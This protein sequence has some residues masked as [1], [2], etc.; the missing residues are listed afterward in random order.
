[1][2]KNNSVLEE[3]KRKIANLAKEAKKGREAQRRLKK[4]EKEYAV[5]WEHKFEMTKAFED[6]Q[7]AVNLPA[8]Y[9]DKDLNINGSSKDFPSLTKRVYELV[10]EKMNIREFL[11]EGDFDKISQYLDKVKA[12]ESLPYN[13]GGEWELRYQGLNDSDKIGGNWIACYKGENWEIK[14]ERGT[15]KIKHKPHLDD[16]VDCYL[17]TADEYGGADQDIK[18][19]YRIKTSRKKENIRDLSLVISGSQS[20]EERLCDIFGYTVCTGSYNNSR[21]RIQRK[22]LDMVMHLETLQPN[23]RYEITVERIGGMIRRKL[24][25][26]K[27]GREA[28]PLEAIDSSASYDGENHLGFTT[29]SGEAEIFDIEIYTR[30]SGFSIDQFRIPFEIEAGINDERLKDRTYKLKIWKSM[31]R[32]KYSYTLLFDDITETKKAL[33]SLQESEKTIHAILDTSL[34]PMTLLDTQGTIIYLNE[35]AASRLGKDIEELIGKC[36]YDFYP[37]E[38]A[39]NRKNYHETVIQFGIPVRF[40]ERQGGLDYDVT[41]YPVFDANADVVRLSVS[42]R[43][44]YTQKEIERELREKEIKYRTLFD[45]LNDAVFL[46]DIEVGIIHDVNRQAEIL[47]GYKK[48]EIMGMHFS[49]LHPQDQFDK[50]QDIFDKH[51][52]LRQAE[53]PNCEIVR[54][55]GRIV[56]VTI[57]SQTLLLEK[58][59]FILV[60]FRDMTEK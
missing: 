56:P 2:N 16:N 4:L 9:L 19:V 12:L 7:L 29:F 6:F 41:V 38:D 58:K 47:T 25:N 54:K 59:G 3:V 24:R 40:E 32:G 20:G 13:E 53:E 49:E 51:V 44:I 27:T 39:E 36:V 45:S 50:Y 8:L 31:N 57:S 21:A 35:V 52:T 43:D 1:M 48:N 15:F 33:E 55:D 14:D 18:V 22:T 60:L 26:L 37:P 23:C 46:A 42:A 10:R 5:L 11:R 30:K 28:K 17:M 34:E